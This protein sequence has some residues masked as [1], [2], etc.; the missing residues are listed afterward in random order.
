MTVRIEDVIRYDGEGDEDYRERVLSL[1][2]ARLVHVPP[3]SGAVTL[4]DFLNEV[5]VPAAWLVDDL[6]P[7]GPMIGGLLGQYKAGKSLSGLQLCFAI[8][9]GPGLFLGRVITKAGATTFIEYEGSRVR[10]Q[11]RARKMAAKYGVSDGSAP[12]SI[13]HRPP[14][15]I[16][17]DEGEAW[18]RAACEDQVL[19]VIGPLSKAASIQRENE[20]AE[21]Q[22]LSERL[23][24]IADATGC[25]IILVHHTRKPSQQYGPPK[26]VDDYFNTAR[27]SNSYMGAVDF[28]LGVQRD[29]DD[30]E[31]VLYYLERDGGAGR[32]PYDFDVPSL[33][34]FE[35][36][37][38]LTKPTRG[39]RVE[40]A[41]T[42]IEDKPGITR[43][44]LVATLGVTW[45]TVKVYLNTLGDRVTEDGTGSQVRTYRPG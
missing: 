43:A 18:L 28:A 42:L 25:T 26:K 5:M 30:T 19:C 11:E 3:A 2:P 7:A 16:D 21:W 34:I 24:R 4:S 14:F 41:F 8:A 27:G 15:K 33:C 9:S 31:G 17:N 6:V 23:Q 13:I 40:Q 44:E 20:P 29:A 37:R 22:E 45:E 35:S 39:D 36:D 1:L 32:L 10:L 38:K 12:V